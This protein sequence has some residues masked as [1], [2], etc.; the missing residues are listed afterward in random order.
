MRVVSLAAATIVLF[1]FAYLYGE[2]KYNG[3]DVKTFW[4]A[5]YFSGLTFTTIGY[6]DITPT[7]FARFLAVLEGLFGIVLSS[8]LVVS[9]VRRHI[10]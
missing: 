6:G 10:E 8:A 9:L 1:A 7:G 5:L 3:N 2:L 4:E